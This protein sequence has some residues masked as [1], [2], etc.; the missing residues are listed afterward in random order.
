MKTWLVL[1]FLGIA[2]VPLADAHSCSGGD[3]GPCVKGEVHAHS[4]GAE[5]GCSSDATSLTDAGYN[6][7]AKTPG[8]PA[9]AVL[10]LIGVAALVV[11]RRS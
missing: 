6:D 2:L 10:V 8:V 9:V 3:C 7:L 5:K 11:G 4:D 1:L